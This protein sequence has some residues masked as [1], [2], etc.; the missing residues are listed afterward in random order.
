M[1]YMMRI[2]VF[3]S[4][5]TYLGVCDRSDSYIKVAIFI[6]VRECVKANE[7]INADHRFR[8][9]WFSFS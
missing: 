4:Y 9:G 6:F 2:L 1:G 5:D 3:P 8:N 7:K